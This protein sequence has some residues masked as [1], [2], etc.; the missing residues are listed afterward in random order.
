MLDVI[1][2]GLNILTIG[3]INFTDGC[4]ILGDK[5]LGILKEVFTYIQIAVPCIVVVMC[6]VD[7]L[8]AVTSQDDK[9]MSAALH[10]S[11]KRL[12]IGAAIFFIPVLLDVF[13]QMAG[14][15][16]GVCNIG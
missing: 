11:I 10:K 7:M 3:A 15:A 12:I 16:T 6:S 5:F 13:L 4:S 1:I 9:G 8:S 2:N 14:L